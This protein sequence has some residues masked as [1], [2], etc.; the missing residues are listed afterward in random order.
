[1]NHTAVGLRPTQPSANPPVLVLLHGLAADEHDLIGLASELNPNLYVVSLRAPHQT[2][3]GG[4]SWFG[5][6]FLPDGSR[7][8][9]E[10]QAIQ[11]REE[12]ISTLE[13]LPSAIDMVPSRL[14]L[15]GFSQGAMMAAAVLLDRPDLI[16]GAWL[17]SGRPL[18]FFPNGQ[19]TETPLPILIQH[20]THDEVL[21]VEEGR[22]L[23][24]LVR[25]SGHDVTYTEY[26]MGH[27]IGPE[28]LREGS[29]WLDRIL[30]S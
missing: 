4:Y 26:P 1:M 14:I 18:P 16:D 5:I 17:M 13:A 2:G 6:Q 20:G 22:A 15:G 12:L 7:L 29:E 30:Q 8:I 27:Q 9:E 25:S 19:I 10:E 11:S 28:S 24:E 21:A 3:Y 23:A